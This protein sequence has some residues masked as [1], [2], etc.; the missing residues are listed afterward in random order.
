VDDGAA[1]AF[2]EERVVADD[3]ERRHAL[4]ERAEADEVGPPVPV[5]GARSGDEVAGLGDGVAQLQQGGS[6][7]DRIRVA[8]YWVIRMSR[9]SG[10]S[11]S[12]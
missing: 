8:A 6:G 12:R 7:A 2:V 5:D 4:D 3:V 10:H 1:S 9:C 11:Q